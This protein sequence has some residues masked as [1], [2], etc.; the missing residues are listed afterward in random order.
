MPRARVPRQYFE[1][2]DLEDEDD[3]DSGDESEPSPAR[4]PL[5]RTTRCASR[6]ETT[7][8]RRIAA[9]LRSTIDFMALQGLDVATLLYYLTWN[10]DDEEDEQLDPD[11]RDNLFTHTSNL[12]VIKYARTA[13]THYDKLPQILENLR[14]PPREHG[15]GIRSQG[16]RGAMDAWSLDN[17]KMLVSKDLHALSA[18]MTCPTS[19]LTEEHLLSINLVDSVREAR[20][21][22]PTLWDL[23][24]SAT[25]TPRQLK[26]NTYKD[27]SEVIFIIMCQL[28]FSRS[29]KRCKYQQLMSIYFKSCG[30]SGKAADTLYLWKICMSQSW[31]YGTLEQIGDRNHQD[32]LHDIHVLSLPISGG[33]D[34]LNLG[35]KTYEQRSDNKSHFDSGCAATIYT[36]AH[37]TCVAPDAKAFQQQW[38]EGAK[39]PITSLDILDAE[40]RG[41]ERLYQENKRIVLK[42]LMMSTEFAFATY[43]Q[44]T[45]SVFVGPPPVLQLP[46]GREHATRQ[47]MLKTVHKEEASL[48][49]NDKCMKEWFLQMRLDDTETRKSLALNKVIPWIGDQLTVCRLRTLKKLRSWDLNWWDRMEVIL[50]LF[51]WF[52]AQIYQEH[53]IIK[54]HYTTTKGMGL[55]HAFDELERKGLG[56]PS[57]QGNYHQTARE[58]LKHVTMAHVQDLWQLVGDV[59]DLT[60]LRTKTPEDLDAIAAKIVTDYASTNALTKLDTLPR[61]EQD[62]LFKNAVM[63]CR[64]GLDYWNFDDAMLSGDV[65]RMELLLPRLLYRYHGGG[66][67]KYTIEI[68]ELF[69]SIL[70]EKDAFLA[71]DMVQ[72]H[73]IRDIKYTFMVLGPFATW[74]Y[75]HKISGS[76]PTQRKVKDHVEANF[77][78]FRRG[79]SHTTPEAEKDI[80]NLQAAYKNAKV[81]VHY[82]DDIY[83]WLIVQR[84]SLLSGAISQSSTQRSNA[85]SKPHL[86]SR[87]NGRLGG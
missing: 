86:V 44:R 80:K 19:N 59:Q 49:G 84:T 76:I 37:P 83:R 24:L 71:Y 74:E 69:Q 43:T 25:C 87:N 21:L 14:C 51:G 34:N 63:Y 23:L 33:H 60:E 7:S 8:H 15:R 81:H 40:I 16:A 57:V 41:A 31:I 72:E 29:S 78:H 2:A 17:V 10:L 67:C 38:H 56:S 5:G 58:A 82:P 66:N 46:I 68:L 4:G 39:N 9:K 28:S 70:R 20:A 75:I 32:M 13:L 22:A 12:G 47:Y 50:E 73:N 54:Q 42:I 11:D 27:P 61:E 62:D 77:N 53:S 18:M 26:K 48:D 52:H 30:V 45:H 36:F 55:K 3:S 6:L 35:F 65:G 79:K 85:G 64:D 1:G